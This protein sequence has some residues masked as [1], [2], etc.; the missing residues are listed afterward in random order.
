MGRRLPHRR[1][2]GRADRQGAARRLPQDRVRPRRRRA[3]TIVIDT[4]RPELI[5][6][7]LRARR[8]PRRRALPAAVR[9]R[10]CARRCSASRCR[11]LAHP[12]AD[13]EKGT[14][15]AMICTFGDITDVIWWRELDLPTRA[16]IGRDG[17]LSHRR[18]GVDH[19][20]TAASRVRGRSPARRRSRPRRSSSS[21]SRES[22][23][24]LGEPRPITH[25]V[26]F[27]EKGDRPL[28]IVASRQWYIRNGGRD[29][30]AARRVPAPRRGAALAPGPHAPPLQQLGRGPQRRLADQPAAV[31]RRARSRCGTRVDADGEPD[32][33]QPDRAAPRPTCRSTRRTDVPDGYTADQRGQPGGFIGDPDI[34]DTWATSSLTPQIAGRLGRR[35]RPVRPGVPDGRP[36]AGPRHHPHLAVLHRRARPLRARLAAVDATPRSRAGSSTPTARRCRRAWAT[37]SRRCRCSSSTAPTPCAT[38]RPARGPASTPRSTRA[39]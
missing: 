39:R 26:K 10:R 3:A 12:L 13:P 30:R 15:I 21:S 37:S 38:G 29:G 1:R 22:G 20:P 2:A 35:P 4:T 36:P 18:A 8:P 24:L 34:M 9:H 5:A 23:A 25:P 14:G 32:Y 28:E 6:V 31:L 17:R 16:L 11:S 27:Y 19:R 33:D 7:V